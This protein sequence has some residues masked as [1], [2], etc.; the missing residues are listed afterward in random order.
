MCQDGDIGAQ[1]SPIG[2]LQGVPPMLRHVPWRGTSTTALAIG[3]VA[4]VGPPAG[5]AG[6]SVIVPPAAVVDTAIDAV[7]D[8]TGP[9]VAL[10]AGACRGAS[11][12]ASSASQR[13]LRSAMLCLVNRKRAG[14]GLGALGVDRRIQRA[15]GRHARDMVRHDYFAHQRAG[16]PDLTARLDRA[17]WHGSAWGETIAYG[18]DSAGTPRAILRSWMHS[19]PHKEILLSGRYRRAG[20]GVTDSA[21][22]GEGAMWVVD[23]GRE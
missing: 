14:H 20:L 17:G 11:A 6:A 15:A 4:A 19:P 3:L 12:L 5:E 9:V 18:C 23:V 10:A 8:A 21:P 22:C 16:G 13:K 2:H 1:V 7:E